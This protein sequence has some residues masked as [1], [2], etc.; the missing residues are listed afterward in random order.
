M[1][2]KEVPI[3]SEQRGTVEAK[4]GK[5]IMNVALKFDE[6]DDYNRTWYNLTPKECK[7]THKLLKSIGKVGELQQSSKVQR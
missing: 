5:E 1:K 4:R 7:Q 3:R 6:H 2:Y